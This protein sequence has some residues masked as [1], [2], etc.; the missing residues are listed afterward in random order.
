MDGTVTTLII[1]ILGAALGVT[2]WL[3]FKGKPAGIAGPDKP[4]SPERIESSDQPDDYRLIYNGDDLLTKG[5]TELVAS[6]SDALDPRTVVSSPVYFDNDLTSNYVTVG[7]GDDNT[8]KLAASNVDRTAAFYLA[9]VGDE[10]RIKANEHSKNGLSTSYKGK[11][12]NTTITFHDTITLYM[13]NVRIDL[14]AARKASARSVSREDIF[15]DIY[16]ISSHSDTA[17]TKIWNRTK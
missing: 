2:L 7:K 3:L 1:L 16:N 13:G 5:P 8:Y 4:D 15:S 11:R 12:I 14:A 10:Y 6:I 17:T 9:K